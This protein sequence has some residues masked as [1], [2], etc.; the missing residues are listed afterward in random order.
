M[1]LSVFVVTYNQE[2][3]IRQCLDGILMQDVDF[4]YEVVIGE[5]HGTDGTRAICEEY[6]AKYQ[7]VRLLPLTEN[8][9]V[10]KN[11]I[12]TISACE[13][14]YIA[15]CE[16]D[17]YWT[18][19]KKLMEQVEFLDAHKDYSLVYGTSKLFYEATGEY[20]DRS[21]SECWE[22]DVFP[23]MLG[24]NFVMPLTA[25]FRKD[26]AMESIRIMKDMLPEEH[27]KTADYPLFLTMARHGKF[28]Y[29]SHSYAVY[30]ILALSI[31]NTGDKNKNAE[32]RESMLYITDLYWRMYKRDGGRISKEQKRYICNKII[33]RSL[34]VCELYRELKMKRK[35]YHRFFSAFRA[36]ANFTNIKTLLKYY[37]C[38][39]SG[40]K[41]IYG[42]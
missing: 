12:R 5:D 35:F 33:Y 32:F 8:L 26:A 42:L 16:G 34:V 4:D 31:S 18:N 28:G 24:N 29:I 10:V 15:L 39:L 25:M 3:Y 2:K 20:K 22:G 30:R 19:E 14:E 6:A 21:T 23:Y 27:W 37:F 40:R 7:Q 41:T 38:Y 11:W 17:D 36:I 1:K 13:G 9:G